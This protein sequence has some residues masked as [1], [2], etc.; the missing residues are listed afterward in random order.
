VCMAGVCQMPPADDM[1]TVDDMA[2]HSIDGGVSLGDM[3]F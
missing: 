3:F 2:L 1:A